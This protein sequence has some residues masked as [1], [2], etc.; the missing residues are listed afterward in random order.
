MTHRPLVIGRL[1][2]DFPVCLAP[3]AGYTDSPMRTLALEYGAGIAFTEVV[4]AEGLIRG[5]RKTIHLLH[6][7]PGERPL[8]AHI[9][10]T[11]PETLARAAAW[12]EETGRFDFIDLNCG[13]PVRKIVQKGAGAALIKTPSKIEELIRAMRTAT[14]LPVTV[15]TRIGFSEKIQNASDVA[16]AAESGG[17]SAIFIHARLASNQHSGPADWEALARVKSERKIPVVGNGGVNEPDDVPKMLSQT[18]VDGVMIGRAAVGRPWIFSEIR[19][20]MTDRKFA[21]P[22]N[23][24]RRAVILEHFRRLMELRKVE[25]PFRRRTKRTDDEIVALRFRGHLARYLCG[26]PRW[27][28]VRRSFHLIDSSQAMLCAIDDVLNSQDHP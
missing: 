19:A 3:M 12:I 20:L 2:T 25:P 9:Y 28:K 4:N 17:A 21:S 26:F 7:L 11:K 5:S 15:K 24:L 1:K 13:C 22:D 8:A 27:A 23:A 18:G 14:T 10:G 16:S 6:S